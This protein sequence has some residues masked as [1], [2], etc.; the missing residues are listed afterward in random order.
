MVH[1]V[2]F[3]SIF[4]KLATTT[5]GV[6]SC[7]NY[8]FRPTQEHL[9]MQSERFAPRDLVNPDRAPGSGLRAPGTGHSVMKL[10]ERYRCLYR[11]ITD[12]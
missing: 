1:T 2:P 6:S 8:P 4:P 3:E 5:L 11:D 9:K 10:L 12:I 7:S